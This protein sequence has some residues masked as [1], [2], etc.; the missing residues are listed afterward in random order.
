MQ[1]AETQIDMFE[2]SFETNEKKSGIRPLRRVLTVKDMTYVHPAPFRIFRLSPTETL[3]LN[4]GV[5]EGEMP[6]LKAV[7]KPKNDGWF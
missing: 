2:E 7:P 5:W 4:D 3:I 6:S 1:Q